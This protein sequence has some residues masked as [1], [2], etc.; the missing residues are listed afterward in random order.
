M[1]LTTNYSRCVMN[2]YFVLFLSVDLKLFEIVGIT[3]FKYVL[4]FRN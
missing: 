2:F 3:H 4:T 1:G